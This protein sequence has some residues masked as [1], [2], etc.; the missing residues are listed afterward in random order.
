MPGTLGMAPLAAAPAPV[1]AAIPGTYNAEDIAVI[2]SIIADNGL[3]LT[4]ANP[5]DGSYV[6]ADWKEILWSDVALDKRITDLNVARESLTGALNVSGL[7][8]LQRL[9]CNN[10]QLSGLSLPPGLKFLG[11]DHNLLAELP[12]LPPELSAL[13]CGSNLLTSLPPLP[14]GLNYLT[15]GSN[16][17]TALPDLPPG[18][19]SLNCLGNRLTALPPLP[20][21]LTALYCDDNELTELQALPPGLEWFTCD[22]NQIAELPTLPLSLLAL[23]CKN[24]QL[25]VMPK[26]PETL[27]TLN[28]NDNQIASMPELPPGLTRLDCGTNN[29]TELPTL[30]NSLTELICYDNQLKSLPTLSGSLTELYCENNRLATLPTFPPGLVTLS[31]YGNDLSALPTLPDGLEYLFCQNNRLRDLSIAGL[32]S[33]NNLFA[34]QN[35]LT[36]LRLSDEAPYTI[37]DISNN[38]FADTSSITGQALPWDVSG[39]TRHS[40]FSPQH[41]TYPFTDVSEGSWYCSS[42]MS[43]YLNDLFGGTTPTTFSPGAPMTRAM[44]AVVLMRLDKADS[45]FENR[46]AE[47]TDVAEGSWYYGAVMWATDNNIASGLGGGRFAPNEPVTREQMSVMLTNYFRYKGA[48]LSIE[49]DEAVFEDEGEI[50]VWAKDAVKSIQ[51]AG[52]IGGKPN[53]LFDPQ[54]NATR[55]EVAA[56]FSRLATTAG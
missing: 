33:L 48:S 13:H 1:L 39:E 14:I 37:I 51:R 8:S 52:I 22:N 25:A 20:P 53:D 35:R 26:L 55:A 29:L 10:N 4:P 19:L 6:P 31:C 23:N 17:L 40:T 15:C 46:N 11:C 5:A 34:G 47:F 9:Y 32:H 27:N 2:N 36:G 3:N 38:Y 21:G 7:L 54:G 41:T 45:G 43:A 24:N 44:F 56:V 12:Q 28:C 30:P 18:L 49:A 50:S 16:Q 42:V